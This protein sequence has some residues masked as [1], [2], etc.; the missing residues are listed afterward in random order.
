MQNGELPAVLYEELR[1]EV[2]QAVTDECGEQ[3]GHH[4]HTLH[5]RMEEA[6]QQMTMSGDNGVFVRL[7]SR[8]PK[9]A[10]LASVRMRELLRNAIPAPS[11][12]CVHTTEVETHIED[13]NIFTIASCAALRVC[14]AADGI[15]LLI[16]SS[17]VYHDIMRCELDCP[18][19]PE[20]E[21]DMKVIVRQWWPQLF[22]P[23]E[24]RCFVYDGFITAI[25]QYYSL[26]FY[27]ELVS[28]KALIHGMICDKWG[29]AHP[30]LGLQT[31]TIDFAISRDLKEI[32][33][34]EINNP[35][36]TAG[37]GLFDFCDPSD[38]RQIETGYRTKLPQC[39]G[40]DVGG[41]VMFL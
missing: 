17:R 29:I 37:T 13:L 14:T 4:L 35:P 39:Q 34:V 30:L 3:H 26:S 41:T 27:P 5:S 21:W 7:G 22:P 15:Q 10:A 8:S 1:R 36:P 2:D 18:G 16:H 40:G 9:D 6:I 38:R 31:Y 19:S 12:A 11:D 23:F 33:V 32:K 20:D 28:N 25:T 24:F